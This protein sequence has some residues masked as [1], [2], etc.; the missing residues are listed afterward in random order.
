MQRTLLITGA[1]RGIGRGL[2][3]AAVAA[4]HTVLGC[5]RNP[6]QIATLQSQAGAPHRFEV[7][8]VADDRQVSEWAV[9]LVKAELIPDLVFNNAGLINQPAPLWKVP[10]EEFD[11]IVD[12]N[13]RG[14][15]SVI[16]HFAPPM[17]EAGR[18]VFVQVSSGWGRS[19]SG[20]VAPYCA[21]KHAIEGLSSALADDLPMGFASVSLSPGVVHTE[22]LQIAF[23]RAGA[24]RAIEPHDWGR[25]ALQY[26][27]EL[28]PKDN[29]ESL[30]FAR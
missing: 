15:A 10:V 6:D 7:V 8:D 2:A 13:I 1:T 27:L 16:R 11:S 4:G 23:G 17:I 9:S 24:A 18:G 22:M 14:V 12:V 29:G 5:G 28:G 3:E 20:D 25:E 26:L 19:T 30:T 21:T